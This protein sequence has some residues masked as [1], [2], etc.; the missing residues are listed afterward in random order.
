MYVAENRPLNVPEALELSEF[1]PAGAAARPS[2]HSVVPLHI[3]RTH[4][5][6]IFALEVPFTTHCDRR[7]S[8]SPDRLRKRLRQITNRRLDL[9]PPPVYRS[10]APTDGPKTLR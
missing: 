10:V 3:T 1:A 6:P 2:S 7:Q 4:D 8:R 9:L 5:A